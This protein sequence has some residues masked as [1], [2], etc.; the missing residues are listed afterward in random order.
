MIKKLLQVFTK[1][2][3][4]ETRYQ[5]FIGNNIDLFKLNSTSESIDNKVDRLKS[6]KY[7]SNFCIK[8][9]SNL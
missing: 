5:E 9:S 1:A 6:S 4:A 2:Y 8:Y 3:K 7:V